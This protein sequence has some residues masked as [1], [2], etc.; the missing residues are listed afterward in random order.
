MWYKEPCKTHWV[1]QHR[2]KSQH[3]FSTIRQKP[4]TVLVISTG[5]DLWVVELESH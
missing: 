5:E 2:F 3:L 1:N 4:I